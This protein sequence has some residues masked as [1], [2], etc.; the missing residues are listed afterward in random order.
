MVIACITH[1]NPSFR[2]GLLLL[3]TAQL[4]KLEVYRHASACGCLEALSSQSSGQ[5]QARQPHFM[6]THHTHMASPA[7]RDGRW[8]TVWLP[9]QTASHALFL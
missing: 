9:L 1:A 6:H 7:L 3:P 4:V 5:E 8:L 2:S